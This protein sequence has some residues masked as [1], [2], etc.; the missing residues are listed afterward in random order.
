MTGV[1]IKIMDK[2]QSRYIC[3]LCKCPH[4]FDPEYPYY[5]PETHLMWVSSIT[6][7]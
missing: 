2:Q 4:S 6:Q 1:G 3:V 5:H 7:L